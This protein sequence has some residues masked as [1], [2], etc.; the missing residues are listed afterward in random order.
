MVRS[1]RSHDSTTEMNGVINNGCV[2]ARG[3]PAGGTETASSARYLRTVRQSQPHSRPISANVAPAACKA[4]KRR[5]FIQDSVSR[6]MSRSPFGHVYLAV[7]E[8]NGDPHSGGRALNTPRPT[9][10]SGRT[11]NDI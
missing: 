2:P 5:M 9:Y 1:A 6:I 7:D 11:E 10:T 8:P 3:G 4:R